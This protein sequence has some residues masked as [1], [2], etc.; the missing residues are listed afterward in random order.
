M[1]RINFITKK[2]LVR[3]PDVDRFC[4]RI[5]LQ[6]P[7]EELVNQYQKMKTEFTSQQTKKDAEL[8]KVYEKKQEQELNGMNTL[9]LTYLQEELL[10]N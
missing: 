8:M 7:P 2:L 10:E 6:K 1:T 5:L 4:K 9:K 3:H